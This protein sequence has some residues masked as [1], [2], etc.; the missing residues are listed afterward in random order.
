MEEFIHQQNLFLL[1]KQLA[2]TSHSTRRLQ[3]SKL[4]AEEE[5]KN[6]APLKEKHAVSLRPSLPHGG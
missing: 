5:A 6:C 2:E 3:L 1:R 4:L